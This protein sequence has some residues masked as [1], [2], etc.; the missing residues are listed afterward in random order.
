MEFT[1]KIYY[2]WG[3]LILINNYSCVEDMLWKERMILTKRI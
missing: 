1:K 2:L 3:D